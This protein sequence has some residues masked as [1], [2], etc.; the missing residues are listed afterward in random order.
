M[1]LGGIINHWIFLRASFLN[2]IRK[3]EIISA[4]VYGIVLA[5][6][7]HDVPTINYSK[8]NSSEF[9]CPEYKLC[10]VLALILS[11]LRFLVLGRLL[12]AKLKR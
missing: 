6:L 7:V 1:H 8:F 2:L 5:V 11:K 3:V 12:L 9:V 10:V 4:T